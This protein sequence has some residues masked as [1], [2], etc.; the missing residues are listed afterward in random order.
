MQV[1]ADADVEV[2]RSPPR[3]PKANVYAERWVSTVRREC[4]DRLL[5]VNQR[6]CVRRT[7]RKLPPVTASPPGE[8]RHKHNVGM[9]GVPGC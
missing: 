7:R 1:F 3:A 4:L 6:A 2:L 8:P 5:I 9:I